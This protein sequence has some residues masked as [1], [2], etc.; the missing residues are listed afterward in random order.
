MTGTRDRI[1]EAALEL[2]NQHGTAAV[3]TNHIA[4]AIEISP[5]NLYYYFRNKEDIIRALFGRLFGQWGEA[6]QL[7]SG[8]TP[9]LADLEGLIV[10]N[11]QLIWEYRFAYRELAALLRNDPELHARYQELRRR[12]YD[13]FA[14]LIEAFVGA[15]ILIRPA[16]AEELGTLTELCWII[17]EQW[18]VDLELRGRAFDDA[19]IQAGI[20]LMRHVFRPYLAQT[21]KE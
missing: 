13:G 14:R 3:S 7:P 17:S 19:G 6:Y 9:G 5:G 1:L 4:A 2:F 12:G 15:G 16:T 10:S 20:A 11:Y 18:P 8:R 21:R